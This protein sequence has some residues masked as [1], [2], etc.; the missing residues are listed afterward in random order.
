MDGQAEHTTQTLE[1]MLR[2]CVTD[3]KGNWDEHFPLIE[4]SYN[5]SHNSSIGMSPFVASRGRRCRSSVGLFKVDD[6]DL[7]GPELVY[8]AIEKVSLIR[9]RLRMTQSRQKSYVDSRRRDLEFEVSDRVYLKISPM[10]G[11][12]IF[13]K[14]QKLIPRYVGPYQILKHIEKVSYELELLNELA[15]VHP[16]FHVPMLKKCIVDPVSIIPLKGLGV[17][18]TLSYEEVPVEINDQK[19]KRLINNE[20][21]PVTVL[22]RN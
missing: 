1:D 21:D 4:F 16:V 9:E 22:L 10:K 12:M 3:F 6:I 14:K 17:D 15:P 8:E 5:I 7:I 2:V 19:V 18:E 20:V 11:V 13:G